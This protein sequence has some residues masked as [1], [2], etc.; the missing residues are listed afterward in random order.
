MPRFAWEN[1]GTFHLLRR[2]M[3]H[4]N[5]LWRKRLPGLTPV[6]FAVLLS[7]ARMPGADQ[8]TIG[9]ASAVEKTTMANL[10]GRMEQRGL[11]SRS[12][13][14]S[15]GRR[16]CLRLT[17][18]GRQELRDAAP[19]VRAVRDDCLAAIPAEQEAVL[20]QILGAMV[21]ANQTDNPPDTQESEPSS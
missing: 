15:D 5:A 2:V 19:V 3:Q 17:K 14:P 11:I 9:E 12:P 16:H 8:Q 21:G 10:I 1:D 18:A 20:R 7:V 4:H 6:Q 13:D